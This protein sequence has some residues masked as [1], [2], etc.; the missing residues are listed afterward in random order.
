MKEP[1]LLQDG[2]G[3]L[4]EGPQ[5]NQPRPQAAFHWGFVA[6]TI[7]HRT[8]RSSSVSATSSERVG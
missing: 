7:G 1:M 6:S 5:P 4:K 2:S 3:L 8:V